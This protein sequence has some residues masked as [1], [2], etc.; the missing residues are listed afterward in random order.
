MRSLFSYSRL[1]TSLHTPAGNQ[2]Q[3]RLDAKNLKILLQ[4][5]SRFAIT[6]VYLANERDILLWQRGYLRMTEMATQALTRR[7]LRAI[8]FK[9]VKISKTEAAPVAAVKSGYRVLRSG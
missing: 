5:R 6:S 7:T 2:S 9:S 8:T 1:L 4:M 3:A